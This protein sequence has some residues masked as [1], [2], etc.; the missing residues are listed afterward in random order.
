[1]DFAEEFFSHVTGKP[2]ATVGGRIA[3]EIAFV[4]A[5][6]A[7]DPHEVIHLRAFKTRAR[8]ARVHAIVD[9]LHDDVAIEVFVVAVDGGFVVDVLVHDV[10]AA[11][12]GVIALGPGGNGGTTG[13]FATFKEIDHLL[14]KIDD[15]RGTASHLIGI[16][17]GAITTATALKQPPGMP[18]HEARGARD[19]TGDE[20]AA[21]AECMVARG[22][23]GGATDETERKKK[24]Q[25]E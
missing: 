13:K 4:H 2:D 11:G 20:L 22:L 17:E 18:P 1:M 3:G 25:A 12:H 21:I 7:I 6:A 15:D 24:E 23:D 14:T 19:V 9:V 16:P 10:V 8:R 5:D